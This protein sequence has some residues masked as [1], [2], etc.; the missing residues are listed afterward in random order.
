MSTIFLDESGFTGQDLLNS[1]QP[2]FT[3]ATLNYSEVTCRQ[4]KAS[5]F[6]NVRAVELMHSALRKSPGQQRMVLA[7]LKELSRDVASIPMREYGV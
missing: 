4:L 6:Q 2:V 5:F 3:V 7:F 1:E